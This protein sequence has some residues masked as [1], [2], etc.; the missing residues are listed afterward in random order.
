MSTCVARVT[1]EHANAVC[2][3]KG[4]IDAAVSGRLD[5]DLQR[6]V[7]HCVHGGASTDRKVLTEVTDL[8]Q[9]R[10][11]AHESYSTSSNGAGSERPC[12]DPSRGTDASNAW[13]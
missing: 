3:K 5:A 13:V 8:N 6:D 1:T 2:C 4:R 12:I 7:F 11:S 9:G 10:A